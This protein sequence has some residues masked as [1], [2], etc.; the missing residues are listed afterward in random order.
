MGLMQYHY[1]PAI[2]DRINYLI[3]GF[4]PAEREHLYW[5]SLTGFYRL[6]KPEPRNFLSKYLTKP[7]IIIIQVFKTS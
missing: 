6:H 3:H 4:N 5:F 1:E 7:F 2:S